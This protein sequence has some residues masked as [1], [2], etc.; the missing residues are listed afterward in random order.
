M[1]FSL[2]VGL[3][4]NLVYTR[5]FYEQT[6]LLYP[7]IE[8][9]FVSYNSTD[10]THQWLDSLRDAHVRYHYENEERTLSD[11]YNTC[12]EL[13][14]ADY[15]IFAHN[16]MVLAPGFIE[17]LAECQSENRVVSYTTVEPPVFAD[18]ERPGKL[19]RDFGADTDTFQRDVFFE[20]SRGEQQR[21]QAEHKQLAAGN[22]VTFFLCVARKVL[23]EVGGLDALFDPMFCED[24]DLILRLKLK[25]LEMA[26]SVNALC[27]HFVSK[28]SRFSDE[29]RQRTT[30]IEARSVRNFV[31]KWGFRIQ[32]PVRK[33]YD[34]GLVLTNGNLALLEELEP[35]SSAIYTDIDVA[36]Y[37]QQEQA[38]TVFDLSKRVKSLTGPQPNGVLVSVDG[39]KM[40]AEKL[41]KIAAI[42]EVIHDRIHTPERW[43]NRLLGRPVISFTWHGYRIRVRDRTSYEHQLIHKV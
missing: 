42:H 15:V 29:Y 30:Q 36:P 5:Y 6:R 18:D 1:T 10:G 13:A 16:D 2:L 19:V 28:T 34:I 31:R 24:D 25:G 35:W 23:L 37:V 3:K 21:N 43:W 32:S 27:Y 14:T 12:T 33:K 38:F 26:V 39:K 4:N 17:H 11:T 40:N 9:V 20:F 8:I 22:W 7:A 41:A